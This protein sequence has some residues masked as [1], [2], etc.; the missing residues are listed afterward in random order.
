M[1]NENTV[2]SDEFVLDSVR[3][4]RKELTAYIK[5]KAAHLLGDD[6]YYGYRYHDGLLSFI[7]LK[8]NSY[9]AGKLPFFYP[10]L[11]TE[12]KFSYK[13]QDAESYYYLTNKNGFCSVEVGYEK[14]PGYIPIEE[15]VIASVPQ[16]MK[17]T[18]SLKGKN[19]HINMILAIL[20]YLSAT[21]FIISSK[22]YDAARIEQRAIAKQS[23]VV[24][25]GLP[26]FINSVAEMGKKVEGKG[27]IRKVTLANRQLSYTI[28][29]KQD[30]DAQVFLKNHG[31]KYERDK[32][33]FTTALS[34]AR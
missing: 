2:F 29:F 21:F 24:P 3:I 6:F 14:Q 15:L 20:L 7:A 11:M 18:W 8:S 5:G 32:I 22:D 1:G 33:V 9:L 31:G 13:K 25:R 28:K 30:A 10:A 19:L 4:P 12:G 26:P 23:P 17:L 16:S 27:Y 34:A